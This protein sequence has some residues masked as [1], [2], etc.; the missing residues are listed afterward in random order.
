MTRP[1]ALLWDNFGPLHED[2][3]R[4]V[5]AAFGRDRRVVGI[6]LCSKSDVY[7]WRSFDD[8][9][10]ERITLFPGQDLTTVSTPR[11]LARLIATAHSLGRGDYVLCHWNLPA[12]FLFA[13]SLRLGGSRVFTMGCSKFDD[14]PRRA[15]K[16][17][18]KATMFLPYQG[19][20]GSGLRSTDYF[21]FLGV[22]AARV[23]GEYNTV[24]IARIRR[25]SGQPI[26]P[27]G[28]PYAE[29]R[30]VSVARL[31][32]K[33]NLAILLDAY[34]IYRNTTT[35]APRS[36]VLCGS[37]PLE[38]TLKQQAERLGIAADVCF[39]GFVQ[40]EEVVHHLADAVALLLPSI[41]EQFGNVV[42][43][44]QAMGLPVILSDNCGARDL[45]IR[46][47]VNGFVVEPDNPEGLAFFM[48][49]LAEDEALWRQFCEAA[50]AV[51]PGGDV[52]E[53][54]RAVSALAGLP[55]DNGTT[56]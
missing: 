16:E 51:A 29:R 42:P 19:A 48:R 9:G 36:L 32:P 37:G 49:L 23:F 10:F 34:R 24:S 28:T 20:I 55:F 3:A 45:L 1:L 22:P 40:T 50:T 33:K 17:M 25:L 54:C 7:G 56:R 27:G 14:K 46:S 35:A 12:I 47:A 2:R 18:L 26:A 31:V 30:F 13:V 5:A 6:E 53:L 39:T 44:A 38:P 52:Q 43:E 8:S 15:W 41:E 4:A 11:L 21:R